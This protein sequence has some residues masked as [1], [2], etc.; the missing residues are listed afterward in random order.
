MEE[1]DLPEDSLCP[2]CGYADSLRH[3]ISECQHNAMV[4]CR[5]EILE[6]LPHPQGEKESE[7]FM[8]AISALIPQLLSTS[9]EP[10]YAFPSVYYLDDAASGLQ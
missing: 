1:Q 3:W 8:R 4:E 7:I 6:S 5:R 9:F 10:D 2:L